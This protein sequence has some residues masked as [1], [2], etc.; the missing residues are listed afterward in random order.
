[1]ALNQPQF[2]ALLDEE[3]SF[4]SARFPDGAAATGAGA[5]V[6]STSTSAKAMK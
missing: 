4:P 1:L 2:S 5:A 3:T 6:L